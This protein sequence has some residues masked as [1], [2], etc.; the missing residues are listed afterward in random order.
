MVTNFLAVTTLRRAEMPPYGD[1]LRMSRTLSRRDWISYPADRSLRSKSIPREMTVLDRH[2][3]CFPFDGYQSSSCEVHSRDW[4]PMSGKALSWEWA[5]G[6]RVAKE[7]KCKKVQLSKWA[8]PPSNQDGLA[9]TLKPIPS[10]EHAR[11]CE[12]CRGLV[13][14]SLAPGNASSG[15]SL[16]FASPSPS[17]EP[18]NWHCLCSVCGQST[19]FLCKNPCWKCEQPILQ[20]PP[21]HLQEDTSAADILGSPTLTPSNHHLKAD[22]GEEAYDGNMILAD[23]ERRRSQQYQGPK[24]FRPI[25]GQVVTVCRRRLQLED[26]ERFANFKAWVKV[27]AEK[28]GYGD[29]LVGLT[30]G[31]KRR[32]ITNK[33]RY[34]RFL[35]LVVQIPDV[36]PRPVELALILDEL[37][38]EEFNGYFPRPRDELEKFQLQSIERVKRMWN[39][40]K[41][42]YWHALETLIAKMRWK[43]IFGSNVD[44]AMRARLERVKEQYDRG[45]RF[46]PM[47]WHF[48]MRAGPPWDL[49]AYA[50][51]ML[52]KPY[53]E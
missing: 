43:G 21:P 39:Q 46:D 20:S 7:W 9:K 10:A 18:T 14:D 26:N 47:R 49:I 34:F 15:E 35:G 36:F 6:S 33:V 48:H 53:I 37:P 16:S 4:S 12:T 50:N 24:P 29:L 38:Y 17:D 42:Y 40:E 30:R 19:R 11:N 27:V 1:R 44:K 8:Q 31:G 13:P 51:E 22:T 3:Q 23:Y 41:R 45:N 32:N 25:V 52:L 5:E 28:N 2:C